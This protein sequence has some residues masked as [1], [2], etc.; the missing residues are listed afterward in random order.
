V[1]SP[2]DFADLCTHV[3]VG[4][5]TRDHIKLL[6]TRL[7]S[8]QCADRPS[9]PTAEEFFV[10]KLKDDPKVLC[11]MAYND[12]VDEFNA[13]IMRMLGIEEVVVLVRSVEMWPPFGESISHL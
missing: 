13:K 9:L 8:Q 7:I 5:P 10:E 12:D 11:L 3:R 2:T 4:S 6:E 1:E